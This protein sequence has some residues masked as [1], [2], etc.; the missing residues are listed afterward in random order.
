[1]VDRSW[2]CFASLGLGSWHL[3]TVTCGLDNG[4]GCCGVLD[5]ITLGF[6]LC[7]RWHRLP[8]SWQADMSLGTV[9][10]GKHCF[11]PS[12]LLSVCPVRLIWELARDFWQSLRLWFSFPGFISF[13]AAVSPLHLVLWFFKPVR[14]RVSAGFHC[15]RWFSPHASKQL[16]KECVGGHTA[17]AQW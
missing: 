12:C 16:Q 6:H 9:L 14:L 11:Y 4:C 1:M 8:E 17:G 3:G 5:V 15:L 7:R 2:D 10:V 13:S